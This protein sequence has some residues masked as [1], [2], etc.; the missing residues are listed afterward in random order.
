M[1]NIIRRSNPSV[2]LSAIEELNKLFDTVWQTPSVVNSSFKMPSIDIYSE[3]SKHMI[4]EMQAPGF[5]ES[6]IEIDVRKGIL[7]IRGES[8][9]SDTQKDTKRN[10]MM[11]E[12]HTSFARSIVLPEGADTDN[13]SAQLDKGIL[14]VTVPVNRPEAKK[15]TITNTQNESKKIANK[16]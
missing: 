15:I 7:E 13:I 6:D 10:Y 4:I 3:D 1:A 8:T 16:S 12:S 5:N 14:K 11:R 9:N 2:G